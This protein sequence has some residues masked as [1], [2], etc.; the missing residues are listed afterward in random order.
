[1]SSVER[2]EEE[3]ENL[4]RAILTA[5]RELLATEDMEKVSMRRI[6]EKI[7]Y[8]P[9][10]IYLHFKDKGELLDALAE[11][12]YALLAERLAAAASGGGEPVERLRRIA[13]AYIAFAMEYKQHYRLMFQYGEGPSIYGESVKRKLWTR[14][15]N[16]TLAAVIE[17]ARGPAPTLDAAAIRSVRHVLWAHMHGAVSLVLAGRVKDQEILK[18]SSETAIAGLLARLQ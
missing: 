8:S 12:G 11:E 9:T 2:R 4:R 15:I 7:R 6:A 13:D 18:Q 17:A 3:R 1:M 10:T 16:E 14:Q 5:S